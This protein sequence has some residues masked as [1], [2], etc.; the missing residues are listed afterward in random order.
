MQKMKYRE[1]DTILTLKENNE[2]KI[3]WETFMD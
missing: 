1:Q 3:F 2:E